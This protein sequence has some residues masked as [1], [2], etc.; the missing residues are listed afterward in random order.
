MESTSAPPTE[1]ARAVLKVH[2]DIKRAREAAGQDT[3][4]L[5]HHCRRDA[6]YVFDVLSGAHPVEELAT[7]AETDPHRDTRWNELF[8]Q[9]ENQ[10]KF[11][12]QGA[13]RAAFESVGD[14]YAVAICQL[15]SSLGAFHGL[16]IICDKMAP[17]ENRYSLV[18]SWINN[19]T[20]D[21]WITGSDTAN[22]VEPWEDKPSIETH[23]DLFQEWRN[24]CGMGAGLSL[25]AIMGSLKRDLYPIFSEAVT[26]GMYPVDVSDE[27]FFGQY[28]F[29]VVQPINPE[30]IAAG[31]A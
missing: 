21:D 12:D 11:T 2:Q 31:G 26:M 19:F 18:Q 10:R 28:F 16:L 17:E 24:R 30:S 7:W 8:G 9:N 23:N 22:T 14:R 6:A 1:L 13:L 29:A 15:G 5:T 3:F 25:S 27:E 20:I 4:M